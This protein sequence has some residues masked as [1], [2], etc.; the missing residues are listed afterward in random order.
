MTVRAALA[1]G[2]LAAGAIR[3]AH[4][5]EV[6]ERPVVWDLDLV[7]VRAIDAG[8]L[9]EKLAT[10]ERGL[11][12]RIPIVG[13]PLFH[14]GD[15]PRLDEHALEVDQRRVEAF[16]RERGYYGARVTGQEVVPLGPGRVRVVLRV[17]EGAPV[18]V[19]SVEVIGLEEAPEAAAKLRELPLREG[20]VFTEAAYD[21]TRERIHSTL[22]EEGYAT[23]AVEQR[24]RVVPEEGT[25]T[26]TYRVE[27]G[28]RYRFG[29][30]EVLGTTAVRRETIRKQAALE[31]KTGRFWRESRLLA[32]QARVFG[33]GVF[34]GVRVGRGTPDPETGTIPVVVA[35]REAPFRTVRA[36]PGIGVEATRWEARATAGWTH[37][38]AFGE[39]Q[40]LSLDGRAGYAWLPNPWD[41][42]KESVVG[43]LGAEYYQP[44]AV[45]DRVD[46]SARAEVERG[47]EPA[48]DFWSLS[49]RIS[50][51][52][53]LAPR[54]SFV[55]SY[56]AELYL[57]SGDLAAGTGQS[58]LSCK[59]DRCVL[60]Y[61]EQ[62]IRWDGVDRSLDPTRGIVASLSL[63]EGIRLGEY[64]YG[65]LRVLPELK[66]Y[67][68]AAP[69]A[70]LALRFRV[71]ALVPVGAD[72]APPVTARFLGGGPGSMRGF[73]TTRLSPYALDASGDYAPVGGN[74]IVDGS[75]ELRLAL[76]T[77]LS[78]ALYVDAGGVSDYDALPSTWQG[79]FDPDYLQ[80]AAGVGLRYATPVGPLRVDL[81]LRIPTR[82]GGGI[83]WS[84]GL[85]PLRGLPEG[86][87]EPVW[88][89]HIALGD[90]L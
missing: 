84:E 31:V 18:V 67:W 11:A 66:A 89:V 51:P 72:S 38:N 50:L 29:V 55:P 25:A 35:V 37:R 70:V 12:H 61:F 86:R 69:G 79:A 65:Y 47:M 10:G 78:T 34:G 32:A 80:W 56:N 14:V 30:I 49:G 15:E 21:L 71:G 54:W 9:R 23:A 76:T 26:V 59:D 1:M 75:V 45:T 77:A 52:V 6:P 60:G 68:S 40:R 22:H 20:A 36:G 43:N 48:Y 17:E 4:A 85:P 82:W 19:R 13:P 7:G 27:A 2:L 33:L 87:N 46:L 83:S 8:A 73:S 5:G 62:R 64:G 53:R 88:A 90:T 57:V 16:Y 39:L 3:P 24:A 41:A 81:A 74:G 63:Q 42:S 44:S 58:E 28:P